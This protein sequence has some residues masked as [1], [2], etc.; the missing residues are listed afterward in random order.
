MRS[1]GW[2]FFPDHEDCSESKVQPGTT[3]A[4]SY[5]SIFISPSPWTPRVLD[6]GFIARDATLEASYK[7]KAVAL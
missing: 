3:Q 2:A 4:V 7:R 1:K 5:K 6:D